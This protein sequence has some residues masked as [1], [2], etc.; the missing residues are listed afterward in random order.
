[1]IPAHA[2]SH[3]LKDLLKA[4]MHGMTDRNA[5]AAFEEMMKEYL[6]TGNYISTT[7][8]RRALYLG[9]KRLGISKG[10]EVILPAFTSDIVPLVIKE[11]GATPIPADVELDSYNMDPQSALERIS[12]K[13]KAI[14]TVH[15][16]GQPSN[17]KE[18]GD[19]C[20]DHRLPMIE[21][22]ASAFGATYQ[23]KPVGT[24]GDIGVFSFG[25]GKSM[26]MGGGGGLVTSRA[27]L[28]ENIDEAGK[29]KRSLDLFVRVVG[30]ILLSNPYVYGVIG[31]RVKDGMVSHEY[32]HYKG[33]I[34][35]RTDN[36][37]LSYSLGMLELH[38][39]IIERR[40]R[41]ALEYNSI[42]GKYKELHPPV[43]NK[44][45]RGTYTR[46]FIRTDDQKI[47]D[48]IL[49][50]MQKYGIEPLVPDMGYPISA[51][52]YPAEWNGKINNSVTLSKTLIGIPVYRKIS[53]SILENI[54]SDVPATW[55]T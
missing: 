46:Y 22:A 44:D 3:N 53:N 54:L 45:T 10:D 2:P 24:F 28:L 12:N 19:I 18:I 16:F 5:K 40:R 29:D 4:T 52:L 30:S 17:I 7:S 20:H 42:I 35:D 25:F 41:I 55:P 1:M 8:G 9:L 36:P 15:T 37:I 48:R 51:D 43:E 50:K 27:D 34:L 14:I 21:D 38:S 39:N 23:N 49:G 6:N 11:A 32:D 26:S 33:E 47:K 13:T 31:Y